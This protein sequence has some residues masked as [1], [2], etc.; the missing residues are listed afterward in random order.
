MPALHQYEPLNLAGHSTNIE[1]IIGA[2]VD[3]KKKGH[4]TG[5]PVLA[6]IK[7]PAGMAGV[8]FEFHPNGTV[9]INTIFFDSEANIDN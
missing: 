5:V 4:N 3:N 9:G 6:K 7:T 8:A 1:N 2:A